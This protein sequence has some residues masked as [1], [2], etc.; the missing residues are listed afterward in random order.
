M[1]TYTELLEAIAAGEAVGRD[2]VLTVIGDAGFSIKQ[3]L[4]D[5]REAVQ[6]L[7]WCRKC[8]RRGVIRSSRE[9]AAGERVATVECPFCRKVLSK[10]ICQTFDF[11]V[12]RHTSDKKLI[13]GA[14]ASE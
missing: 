9:N 6:R 12:Y 13:A 11:C 1:K 14:N 5:F 3:V 4:L 7:D 8:G 2:E 10:Q